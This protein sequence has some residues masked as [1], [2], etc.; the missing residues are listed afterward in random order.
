MRVTFERALAVLLGSLV[1]ILG[2]I[3]LLFWRQPLAPTQPVQALVIRTLPRGGRHPRIDVIAQTTAGITGDAIENFDNLH[4]TVGD[5]VDG[6]LQ[7][8]TLTI[9]PATCRPAAQRSSTSRP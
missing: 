3:I 4:C 2:I 9:K 8:V 7:G 6:T 5:Q 1:V